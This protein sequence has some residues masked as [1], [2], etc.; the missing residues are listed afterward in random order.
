MKLEYC[1][2]PENLCLIFALLYL[3]VMLNDDKKM[4][5]LFVDTMNFVTFYGSFT[6]I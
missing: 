4:A 2:R 1:L 6:L 3:Y 5:A